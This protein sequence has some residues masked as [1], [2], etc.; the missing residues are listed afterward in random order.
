MRLLSALALLCVSIAL[1][2]GTEDYWKTI[3]DSPTAA[4][5]LP[6]GVYV[7]PSGSD[8]AGTPGTSTEPFQ[9]INYAITRAV[10]DGQA[11][12]HV[13]TGTYAGPIA[14]V[15][16]ISLYGGYNAADWND[17]NNLD[18]DNPTYQ[19]II[20][21]VGGNGIIAAG[22][23]TSAT[24]VD[25]FT[26]RG[27]TAFLNSAHSS[28]LISNNTIQGLTGPNAH[29]IMNDNSSPTI[30]FNTIFA[31]EG[32]ANSIG[33]YSYNNSS[34]TIIGNRITGCTTTEIISWSRGIYNDNS[35]PVIVGNIIDAAGPNSG[36]SSG[37]HNQNSD[38]IIVFNYVRS[39]RGATAYG[40]YAVNCSPLFISNYIEGGP[41]PL[42]VNTGIGIY[43]DNSSAEIYNNVVYAG[44]AANGTYGISMINASAPR[45]FNNTIDGG[46]ITNI[47]GVSAGINL[48]GGAPDIRNN[49]VLVRGT[50]GT[51]AGIREVNAGA[52]PTELHNNNIYH[53][54]T[55]LYSDLG[56][57][58]LTAIADVNDALLTTQG[59]GPSASDNVSVVLILNAEYR[60][61]GA[62][63]PGDLPLVTRGG[64][65]LSFNPYL[66]ED[67][68]ERARTVPWSIGA[69]EYN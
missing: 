61:L 24:V 38:A 31:G 35:T 64:F 54:A 57:G 16:G 19:T 62:L 39:G 47:G 34:P 63:V 2:C 29:G 11:A 42:D 49:I 33:I 53:C 12:V 22:P 3:S 9:T 68:D 41:D 27:R 45:I 37:I 55:A 58:N 56:N 65:D 52:D 6:P 25:G 66:L 28:P 8:L 18:R 32:S 46:S 50:V 7:H 69:Y 5:A 26:I 1:S 60:I 43:C 30:Q 4:H 14:L 21:L 20:V 17:R 44:Q 59:A 13:A 36:N 48:I 40:L 51:C 15:E 67:K 10:A 23:I